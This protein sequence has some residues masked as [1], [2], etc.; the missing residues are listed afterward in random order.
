VTSIER[1]WAAPARDA[2]A[3]GSLESVRIIA[4]EA[5]DAIVWDARR[6]GLWQRIG[7]RFKARD[8]DALLDVAKHAA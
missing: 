6:P 4:E 1:G 5:G 7:G 8:L 3:A 2:L